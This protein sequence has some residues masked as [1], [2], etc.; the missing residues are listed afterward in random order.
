MW[1]QKSRIK[2]I[3]SLT[4]K[5]QDKQHVEKRKLSIIKKHKLDP[6][7]RI[8]QTEK[9]R[10]LAH[11]KPMGWS[12]IRL[13]A[14]KRDGYKCQECGKENKRLIVHHK[15]HKG[16]NLPSILLMNNNLD[17]LITLCSGCHIR[18]HTWKVRK[19]KQVLAP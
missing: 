3:K 12:R 10:E 4:G 19:S 6:T 5:K 8:R 1:K 7:L 9:V 17:N 11:N 13:I 14:L 16:R 18:I 2:M 15:D